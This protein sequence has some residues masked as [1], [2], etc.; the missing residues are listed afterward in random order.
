MSG[1]GIEGIWGFCAALGR[2]LT[3]QTIGPHVLFRKF[4]TP[5]EKLL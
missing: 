2:V 5:S 4:A 1:A 3:V